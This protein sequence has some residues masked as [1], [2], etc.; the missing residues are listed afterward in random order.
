MM[1]VCISTA[2]PTLE[3]VSVYILFV[4]TSISAT[5]SSALSPRVR[6]CRRRG[7]GDGE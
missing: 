4:K 5:V 3:D 2:R 1:A 7:T 6:K